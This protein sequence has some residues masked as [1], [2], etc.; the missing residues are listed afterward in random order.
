MHSLPFYL[1]LTDFALASG[2]HEVV[3]A[4][5]L[6]VVAFFSRYDIALGAGLSSR[7]LHSCGWMGCQSMSQGPFLVVGE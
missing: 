6:L 7:R 1:F 4:Y 3:A 2:S 5:A